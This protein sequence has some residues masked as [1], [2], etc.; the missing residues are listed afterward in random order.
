MTQE[1]RQAI[2][3]ECARLVARYANLGVAGDWAA[4]ADLYVDDGR[5][6][7]PSAPDTWIEGRT[8][9]LNAFQARLPRN[10]RH[11]CTNVVIDVVNEREALGESA[12]G[13]F[14]E[15]GAAKMGSFHDRFVR[16]ASGWKFAER[17]GSIV[18]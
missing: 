16:T 3:H 12:V 2:E 17:R 11:L 13:L 18:F 7:R 5:L 6:S 15:G 8:A 1:E 4:L 14:V 10:G 9:I